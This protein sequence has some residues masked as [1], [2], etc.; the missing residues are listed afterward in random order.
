MITVAETCCNYILPK[1]YEADW[2][3]EQIS[4]HKLTR[5]DRIRNYR[6]GIFS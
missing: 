6:L 4:K 5:Q 2:I 1:L 3:I